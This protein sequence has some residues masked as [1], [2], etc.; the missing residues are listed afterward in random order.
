MLRWNEL[1]RH[2]LHSRTCDPEVERLSLSDVARAGGRGGGVS[3]PG[4][5]DRES[6]PV[7]LPLPLP[8][9]LPPVFVGAE[10]ASSVEARLA[11]GGGRPG[12][13]REEPSCRYMRD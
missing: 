9:P 7:P 10:E 4:D 2:S 11:S 1:V 5:G 6:P 3:G 13:G 12:P 8:L